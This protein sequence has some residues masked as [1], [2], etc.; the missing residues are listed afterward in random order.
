MYNK[1]EWIEK[2]KLSDPLSPGARC[3]RFFPSYT[4]ILYRS[5]PLQGIDL[6]VGRVSL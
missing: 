6:M 4:I 1:Y 5:S 3:A 2:A